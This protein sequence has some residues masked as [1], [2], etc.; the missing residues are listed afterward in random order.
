MALY[1][2][3]ITEE[4][5]PLSA[6][7]NFAVKLDKEVQ[8]PGGYIGQE[9]LRAIAA[10]GPPRRLVGLEIASRRAA[11]QHMSVLSGETSVG[12]VTSGCLSPTLERSIA[13]A[14][15][16]ASL[17]TN[18]TAVEIDLGRAKASGEIVGLPFYK[19]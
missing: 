4:I 17:A 15:V 14:H 10:S 3:E 5:D 7:L 11:R 1:G 12:S 13:M 16:D 8:D 6:G 2:H 18:G 19:S 9:A